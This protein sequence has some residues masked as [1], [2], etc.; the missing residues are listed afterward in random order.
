MNI[1][2]LEDSPERQKKF[3]SKIPCATIVDTAEA[4]IQQLQQ[5]D[6]PWDWIFLDH[7]LGGEIFVDTD[8]KNTGSEVV[9][10]ICAN[11]PEIK[12]V[13]IHSLN[14]DAAHYMAMDLIA[15]EYDALARPFHTLSLEAV[16]EESD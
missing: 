1:L 12:K 7:D 9:R 14:H 11:K 3:R 16:Y 6:E 4:C 2:I 15:A 8:N 5:A 10:W 13:I